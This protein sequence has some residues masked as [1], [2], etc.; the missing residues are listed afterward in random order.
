MHLSD[1]VAKDVEYFVRGRLAEPWH[2]ELCGLG[3]WE[4]MEEYG[5][6]IVLGHYDSHVP[7][8]TTGALDVARV[9]GALGELAKRGDA[10]CVLHELKN[11]DDVLGAVAAQR[12]VMGM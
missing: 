7:M 5:V 4:E 10:F 12:A 1:C 8:G 11:E 2:A 6:G 9:A 3:S